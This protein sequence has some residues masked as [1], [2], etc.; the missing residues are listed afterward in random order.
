[1][2]AILAKDSPAATIRRDEEGGSNSRF[3]HRWYCEYLRVDIQRSWRAVQVRVAPEGSVRILIA[4]HDVELGLLRAKVL[5]SD[6]HHVEI[7]LN[8]QQL[9]ALVASR[10][11]D[12][13]LVC[14]SLPEDFCQEVSETFRALNPGARVV[15]VLKHEWADGSCGT[16]H[17][18]AGVAGISGH[19]F[20]RYSETLLRPDGREFVG[21]N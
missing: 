6:G 17:F 5:E 18:D 8:D 13:L 11:Y 12:L 9:A 15:G 2:V 1:M 7:G 16:Q 14:H 3:P 21:A 10:K 20:R 4:T 19:I